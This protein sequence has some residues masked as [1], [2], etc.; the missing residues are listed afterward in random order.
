LLLNSYAIF[1]DHLGGNRNSQFCQRVK[2]GEGERVTCSLSHSDVARRPKWRRTEIRLLSHSRYWYRRKVDCRP[3]TD[4]LGAHKYSDCAWQ[5]HERTIRRRSHS[6]EKRRP[7][8]WRNLSDQCLIRKHTAASWSFI[9]ITS[10]FTYR[11]KPNSITLSDLKLV[12][13]WS[14]TCS[15]LKFDLS[16]SLLAANE[17]ELAGPRPA[18]NLSATSFEP[19]SVKE[20]AFY[21]QTLLT[22]TRLAYVAIVLW[23]ILDYIATSWYRSLPYWTFGGITRCCLK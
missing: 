1:I 20:F 7:F 14:Q 8:V 15:E 11:L 10:C 21:C 5:L 17:L 2:L 23:Y 12:G 18:M 19:D 3:A 16:S 13:S 22:F 6:N 9:A 4:K